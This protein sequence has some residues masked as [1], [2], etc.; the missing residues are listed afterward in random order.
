MSQRAHT[1]YLTEVSETGRAGNAFSM[2]DEETEAQIGEM[3]AQSHLT[4]RGVKS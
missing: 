2:T 3:I 4:N 1:H